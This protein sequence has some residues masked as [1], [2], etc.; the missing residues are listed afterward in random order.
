MTFLFRVFASSRES[1]ALRR[2]ASGFGI[3]LTRS[4]EDAK[5]D[6]R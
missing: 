5:E 3:Y 1:L 2:Q 4:R 6:W